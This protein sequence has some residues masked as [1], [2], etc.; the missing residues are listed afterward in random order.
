MVNNAFKPLSEQ[1]K[2]PPDIFVNTPTLENF[3]D[4]GEL[5]ANSLV[6][7]SRHLFNTLFIVIVGT[8]GQVVFASMAAYPLAKVDFAGNEFLSKMIVLSLMFTS[9][10]TAVPNYVIMS[11]L[12][13]VDT[14]LALI[15]PAFSSTLGLYLMKNFMTQVPSSLIE[16]AHID[17]ANEMFTLWRVVMPAVKPAWI[18]L[19][20]F[21][22]QNMW[23]VTGNTFIYKENLKPIS[24]AL[25]QISSVGIA[26][27]GVTAAVSLV[28]FLIPITIYIFM[29]SNVLETMSTSGMKD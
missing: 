14:Y 16:A 24:Y 8:A 10:V 23:G 13:L 18:T 17:G 21:S 27:Q 22:F 9:A 3:M 5:F 19:F 25:Q 7:F 11:R 20:I 15:L 1:L 12:G 26:R 2:F 28:M 6:P 29:Q 4:L